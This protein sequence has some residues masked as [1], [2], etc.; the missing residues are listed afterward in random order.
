MIQ[1]I[2]WRHL[3]GGL[4]LCS[5]LST[6]AALD[7]R[8]SDEFLAG[9]EREVANRAFSLRVAGHLSRRM[10][11]TD[12][13]GFWSAYLRLEQF[14]A[15]LYEEVAVKWGIAT[16]PSRW[17]RFRAWAVGLT[18][19]PMMAMAL[20]S[21]SSRTRAY[22]LTL[23]ALQSTGPEEDRVFLDYM[24]AQEQLQVE[25]MRLALAGSMEEIPPLVDAFILRH[26]RQ[27]SD[28]PAV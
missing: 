4:V 19:G 24:V 14:N 7:A 8:P 22:V 11:D 1:S 15:P 18:P 17:T 2:K 12:Y 20:E 3:V 23:Q 10:V 16:D 6:A 9:F 25:M 5:S 26:S 21:T 13:A 27:R 28:S